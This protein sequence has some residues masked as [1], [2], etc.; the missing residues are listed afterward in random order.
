M[1]D[2]ISLFDRRIFI[3]SIYL[4]IDLYP[5]FLWLSQLTEDLPENQPHVERINPDIVLLQVLYYV[6]CYHLTDP[7]EP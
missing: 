5:S 7:C 6:C 2:L 4:F 1:E 3:L